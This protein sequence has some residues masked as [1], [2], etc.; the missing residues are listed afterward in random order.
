MGSC[1]EDPPKII[2]KHESSQQLP[3]NSYPLKRY[4]EIKKLMNKSADLNKNPTNDPKISC[5][6]I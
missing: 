1:C 5:I 6:L 2:K 3:L 4:Q